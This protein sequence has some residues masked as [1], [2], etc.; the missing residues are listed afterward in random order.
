MSETQ[1]TFKTIAEAQP[2][3]TEVTPESPNVCSR[4][5]AQIV[6]ETGPKVELGDFYPTFTA[7]EASTETVK[8]LTE[9]AC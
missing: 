9:E 8:R 4:E 2:E 6:R 7:R 3:T 5:V 1:S